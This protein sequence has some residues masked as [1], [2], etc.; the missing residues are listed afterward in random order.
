MVKT[1]LLFGIFVLML[2]AVIL[3]LSYLQILNTKAYS[4]DYIHTRKIYPER[5]KVLDRNMQPL[6]LNQNK[7]VLFAEPKIIQDRQYLIRK[8][9]EVLHIGEAT[10]ESRIDPSKQ[11]VSIASGIDENTK[12]ILTDMNLPGIG[13]DQHPER[14]YPEASLSAHVLGF[15]GK[16][17][18][19]EDIGYVGIEG[20]YDKELAGLPGLIS[21]ERDLAGKPIFFGTQERVDPENGRDLVLTIDK[22]VQNIVKKKLVAAM[23]QYKAKQVCAIIANP[24]TGEIL[25]MDCVPDFDPSNYYNYSDSVFKNPAITD[26]YEPGSTF[27][28]LV[29]AA[30]IQE[31]AIKP[32]ETMNEDGPVKV[33][34]YQIQTWDNKY[35]GNISMTR[36][37]EKSSNVGMVYI[38]DKLGNDKLYKYIH[39][40]GFGSA[41]NIDLQGE[42]T[43][44][45]KD[46]KDWYAIDYATATFGQGLAVTPMQMIQAFSAIVNGGNLMKPYVVYK[47]TDGTTSKQREPTV[48]RRIISKQ[49]SEIMKKMLVDTVEHGEVK[50]AIPKGYK[51]GGKT[52]TAQ[53]AI[54]GHYDAS[55]TNA[56]F[57]GFAP[58]DKP[59][60]IGLVLVKEPQSS[61]WGSETAA[62]T[63]FDIA[64]DL[65]VYYN[66][67]PQ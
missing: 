16:N 12:K 42:A 28:P 55:K 33:G 62:P 57:I 41:T 65:L 13:F 35:E 49:T 4:A 9:D 24:M 11:W 18:K 45:L 15:V 56:S 37:L 40:Y 17:N 20:F 10:L 1:K 19:G 43:G 32:D 61:E 48:I 5:G 3:K 7:Y 34:G 46:R 6:A 29:M 39:D 66:I 25:A 38:G 58:A 27:K 14:Y 50:W 36:I 51:F 52:G 2:F 44:Y 30:G 53:I 54:S 64:K 59:Q 21:S 67:P 23:D 22:A 8:L 63:F 26:L 47:T 31:K 60:F